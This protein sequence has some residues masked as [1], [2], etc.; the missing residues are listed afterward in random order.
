MKTENKQNEVLNKADDSGSGYEANIFW[1]GYC[2]SSRSFTYIQPQN[3]GKYESKYSYGWECKC[4][5]NRM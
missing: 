3:R 4:C 5:K 1:C 2:K